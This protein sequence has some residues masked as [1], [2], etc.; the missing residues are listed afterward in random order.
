VCDPARNR[1]QLTF[2]MIDEGLVGVEVFG[3]LTAFRG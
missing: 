3:E 1:R 2:V